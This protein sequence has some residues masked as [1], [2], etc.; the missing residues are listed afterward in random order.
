MHTC[1]RGTGW[2]TRATPTCPSS[3]GG[4]SPARRRHPHEGTRQR[5]RGRCRSAPSG[6]PPP[7]GRCDPRGQPPHGSCLPGRHGAI[8]LASPSHRA[9]GSA[10]ASSFAP[11]DSTPL[12]LK[13]DALTS[14]TASHL[15]AT[16]RFLAHLSSPGI[17]TPGFLSL[18]G[19][20][21]AMVDDSG[22]WEGS[23]AARGRGGGGRSGYVSGSRLVK[24]LTSCRCS[25][26]QMM[27]N[28]LH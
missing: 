6:P 25:S 4:G 1:A 22:V 21:T 11:E 24:A 7:R 23:G 13:H 12:S 3:V 15:E 10:G 18:A 26:S 17:P 27:D 5:R 28:A 20:T 14:V 8:A 9:R 19:G 16:H 2:S